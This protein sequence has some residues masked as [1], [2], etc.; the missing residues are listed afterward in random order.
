MPST[1]WTAG[2]TSSP[3]C[4]TP[5]DTSSSDS[6]SN[7]ITM[8]RMGSPLRVPEIFSYRRN[9]LSCMTPS[10]AHRHD[11]LEQEEWE[12]WN[13]LL[14]LTRRVLAELDGRLRDEHRLGVTE[15]DVLITL[16]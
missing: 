16:F 5:A 14:L 3:T 8:A 1:A 6:F 15:F 13:A 7:A 12:A 9:I 2:T 4:S 10:R 11:F